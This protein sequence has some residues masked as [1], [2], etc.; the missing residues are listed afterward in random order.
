MKKVL[1]LMLVTVMTLALVACGGPPKEKFDQADA[2]FAKIEVLY[3]E[4][5]TLVE[6]INNSGYEDV[7]NVCDTYKSELAEVKTS[8][9]EMKKLFNENR[10]TYTEEELDNI[11][12]SQDEI[13]Q[14]LKDDKKVTEDEIAKIEQVVKEAD[15]QSAQ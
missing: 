3:Q 7:Q 4:N 1:A 10:D 11:L 9:D 2:S 15:A 14:A 8:L 12:K 13:V 6:K 5:L